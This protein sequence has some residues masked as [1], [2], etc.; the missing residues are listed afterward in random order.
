[1]RSI[2]PHTQMNQNGKIL[3]HCTRETKHQIGT[4]LTVALVF[5]SLSK[6]NNP[7]DLS[8]DRTHNLT[9]SG[10]MLHPLSY[11]APWE[12]GGGEEGI[13]VAACSW[14]PLH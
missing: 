4:A 13:Q 6:E 8:G 12:Q 9:I 5:R 7:W 2:K 10:M 1:M 3:S 11:Q 14:C